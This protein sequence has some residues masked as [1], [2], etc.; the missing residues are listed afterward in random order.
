MTKLKTTIRSIAVASTLMIASLA[1][2]VQAGELSSQA[3]QNLFD[4]L[5]QVVTS[6]VDSIITE[7]NYDIERSIS[8]SLLNFGQPEQPKNAKV[9]ITEMPTNIDTTASK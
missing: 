5:G 9:T 6:Q 3:K 4:A 2:S 7:I 8:Q 1:T